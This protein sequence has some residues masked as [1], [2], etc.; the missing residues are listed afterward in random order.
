[1]NK[2]ILKKIGYVTFSNFIAIFVSGGLVLI[3][4]RI[5]SV[6]DY[7]AWQLYLFYASYIGLLHLGWED[8]IYL[9][10]AGIKYSALDRRLFAGQIYTLM[11]LQTLMAI[12]I[13]IAAVCFADT[14][15]KRKVLAFFSIAIVFTNFNNLCNFILQ[16]TSRIAEYSL[17]VIVERILFVVCITICFVIGWRDY[18]TLLCAQLI[19]LFCLSIMAIRS[20]QDL[21]YPDFPTIREIATEAKENLSAGSK[22]MLANIASLLIVGIIR[23][24]ISESWSISTFGQVSLTLSISNFF[25]VAVNAGSVVFFPL[26]KQLG[27]D[28]LVPV[29]SN[30]RE[31][32]SGVSLVLLI[33]YYPLHCILAWWL[34]QYAE[35]LVYMVIL[36]PVC[37]FESRVSLLTNTYL[38][39]LRREKSMLKINMAAVVLSI[40]L[41]MI[42][43]YVIHNLDFMVMSIVL[44]FAFRC[45]LAEIYLGEVLKKNFVLLN[46][47]ESCLIG[48]F[49]LS[50]WMLPDVLG[51][52]VFSGALGCFWFYRKNELIQAYQ[53]IKV[54]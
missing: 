8:G 10:Y 32:L 41:T 16:I 50:G 25:L 46:I 17:R 40:C 5:V 24:G 18:T 34:P 39:T 37:V 42:G 54:R 51:G 14:L 23:Y 36:F 19:A 30:I 7:G 45:I 28:R 12:V 49:I 35:S 13:A 33:L 29:Y 20:I 52:L 11:A 53:W 47:V 1:M 15:M 21:L 26:L 43:C 2:I 31:L 38:K 27:K 22:L 9:R 44:C 48:V 4:P 6:E 3:V